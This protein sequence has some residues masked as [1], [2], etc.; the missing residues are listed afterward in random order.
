MGALLTPNATSQT[1][2]RAACSGRTIKSLKWFFILSCG[3]LLL[4]AAGLVSQG[5]VFFT[6]SG[7]FGTLFPY[8]VG[9]CGCSG[10]RPRLQAL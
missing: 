6:S 1:P 7:L 3:L 9:R 10:T 8:E 4:I 2:A 5:V